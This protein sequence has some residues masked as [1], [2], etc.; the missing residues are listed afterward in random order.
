M[1]KTRI[2][3][4]AILLLLLITLTSM[5]TVRSVKATNINV[6]WGHLCHTNWDYEEAQFE[7]PTCQAISN[8]FYYSGGWST[9][10]VYSGGT[11]DQTTQ[12][13]LINTLV[14]RQQNNVWATDFWVGDFYPQF[15]QGGSWEIIGYD[16]VWN[17]ETQQWE[18]VEVWGWV[19]N[20]TWTL[21]Y[22][23]Y[24]GHTNYQWD[25]IKDHV[26]FD[27]TNWPYSKQYFPFIWACSCGSI[28]SEPY[29]CYGYIDY[30]NGTWEVGMPYAWTSR[31]DLS[32]Y[33]YDNPDYSNY[34][35]I[36]FDGPSKPL[37]EMIGQTG[38]S[39]SWF[40]LLVYEYALGW[41]QGGVHHTIKQSLDYAANYIWGVDYGDPDCPL[42]Y[43]YWN[44]DWQRT[45]WMRVF[46]NPN[47]Y[48][49]Y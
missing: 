17:E 5:L 29:T 6:T 14:W 43:G 41:N 34:C 1:K 30:E 23:L 20:N 3:L 44:Y 2:A 37:K 25:D 24:G 9:W 7:A 46:G 32:L 39:Y 10:N 8:R 21:H 48:L 47:I 19:Y 36:G 11:G 28:L 45:C 12:N 31:N 26:V 22:Y 16:W 13:N 4:C 40:P 15:E 38:Y 33:G 27:Y 18:Y 49:P 35:Y 42:Y